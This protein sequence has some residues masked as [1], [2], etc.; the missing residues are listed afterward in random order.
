MRTLCCQLLHVNPTQLLTS[1]YDLS[2]TPKVN[3]AEGPY[4]TFILDPSAVLIDLFLSHSKSLCPS[5]QLSLVLSVY[6]YLC[7]VSPLSLLSLC[8]S[9]PLYLSFSL[10]LCL[11]SPLYIFP[12][13]SR[14][15]CTIENISLP[16][17]NVF[18]AN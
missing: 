14:S 10:S 16:L 12:H 8:L 11:S 5:Y 3:I 15:D 18:M 7:V 4:Q 2:K 17:L 13:W 6:L 9:H 1:G